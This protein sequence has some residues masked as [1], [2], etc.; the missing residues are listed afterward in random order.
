LAK[1]AVIAALMGGVIA[2]FV[3]GGFDVL[4]DAD[5]VEEL[6][7]ESGPWGPLLFI[8]AFVALQPFSLPGALL[9]IPGTFVWPWWQVAIY[10]LAG[11]ML[12]STIGFVLARWLAQDWVEKRLPQRLRPWEQRLAEHGLTATIALRLVTGYAPAADWLLG[13]SRVNVRDF[14]IGT[15]IGLGPTTTLM[16]IWGDEAARGV[17]DYPLQS[18]AILAALGGV[19][20]LLYRRRQRQLGQDGIGAVGAGAFGPEDD[21][22]SA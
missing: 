1:V 4:R 9:I 7:T 14:L 22:K 12:A 11:G 8:V 16:A 13:V 17:V 15:L 3:A 5:R 18:A 19:G 20:V 6:L 2:I 10:S 21:P